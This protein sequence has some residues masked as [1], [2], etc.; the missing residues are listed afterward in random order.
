MKYLILDISFDGKKN[1]RNLVYSVVNKKGK[2]LV[3]PSIIDLE[4]MNLQFSV[5]AEKYKGFTLVTYNLSTD[6]DILCANGF[7]V[8]IFPNT[9]C[10]WKAALGNVCNTIAYRQFAIQSGFFTKKG[11]IQTTLEVVSFFLTKS[12]IRSNHDSFVDVSLATK[13]LAHIL[14]IKNWQSNI[15]K[16]SRNQFIIE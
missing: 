4:S 2:V 14:A 15:V 3:S 1:I 8:S 5:L 6:M 10:L 16:Y 7:D 9:I 13:V 12:Y 11:T